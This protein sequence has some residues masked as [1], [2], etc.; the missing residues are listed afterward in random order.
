MASNNRGKANDKYNQRGGVD[1]IVPAMQITGL[2]WVVV[3]YVLKEDIINHA[4]DNWAKGTSNRVDDWVWDMIERAIGV[5]DA[6]REAFVV[7]E[8]KKIQAKYEETSTDEMIAL[9][10]MPLVWNPDVVAFNAGFSAD[11]IC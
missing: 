6:D 4:L 7:D 2:V 11:P 9:K 10:T 5:P 1:M 8:T 3:K